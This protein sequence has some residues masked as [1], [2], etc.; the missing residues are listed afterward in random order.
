M[1]SNYIPPVVPSASAPASAVAGDGGDSIIYNPKPIEA[2]GIQVS[3]MTAL[4][5]HLALYG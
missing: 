4:I 5:V 1:R 2:I 3:S